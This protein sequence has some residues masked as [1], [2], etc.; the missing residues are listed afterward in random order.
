MLSGHTFVSFI[1][2]IGN[3]FLLVHECGGFVIVFWVFKEILE[4]SIVLF[5]SISFVGFFD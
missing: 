1:D 4:S 3:C 2:L 5:T